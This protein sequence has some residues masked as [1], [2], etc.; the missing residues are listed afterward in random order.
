MEAFSGFS[1][2]PCQR[3]E[4]C[5]C[6]GTVQEVLQSAIAHCQRCFSED[7]EWCTP[8]SATRAAPLTRAKF[9]QKV[10][11]SRLLGTNDENLEIIHGGSL[12]QFDL[13]Y[14][15]CDMKQLDLAKMKFLADLVISPDK[16][17]KSLGC[18]NVQG[19]SVI[20]APEK[21]HGYA[22]SIRRLDLD[23]AVDIA[24]LV[25]YWSK[26][27]PEVTKMLKAEINNAVFSAQFVATSAIGLEVNRFARYVKE[28]KQKESMGRSSWLQALDLLRLVNLVPP[29]E[30]EGK[31]DSDVAAAQLRQNE[32]LKSWKSDTCD[33]CLRRPRFFLATVVSGFP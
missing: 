24:C 19:Q 11:A 21:F 30:K 10:D 14:R 33:R 12:A 8:G 31:K 9:A 6:E 26:D 27:E 22:S 20:D 23:A 28:D 25:V 2:A 4:E 29:Q 13:H 1:K 32:A 7:Q 17:M 15:A 18:I 16:L 5:V 3:L